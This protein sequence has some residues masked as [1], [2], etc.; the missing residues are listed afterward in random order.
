MILAGGRK[1]FLMTIGAGMKHLAMVVTLGGLAFTGVANAEV[2]S[3]ALGGQR[4]VYVIRGWR[5]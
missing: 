1:A 5:H 2:A 4:D 3:A